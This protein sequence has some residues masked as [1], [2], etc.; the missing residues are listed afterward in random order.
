MIPMAISSVPVSTL[1]VV[2]ALLVGSCC[3]LDHQRELTVASG[4]NELTIFRPEAVK[5]LDGIG[6]KCSKAP[7]YDIMQP[8]VSVATTRDKVLHSQRRRV[9]EKAF[10]SSGKTLAL[11]VPSVNPSSARRI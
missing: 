2:N 1:L 3:V 4:P 11:D 9:W 8:R 10:S 7:W 6:T 5:A